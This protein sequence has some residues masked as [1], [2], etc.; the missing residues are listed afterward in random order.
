MTIDFKR[1]KKVKYENIEHKHL[2]FL[3]L[4]LSAKDMFLQLDSLFEGSKNSNEQLVEFFHSIPI[5]LKEELGYKNNM[6]SFKKIDNILKFTLVEKT[7]YTAK[8]TL[9]ADLPNENTLGFLKVA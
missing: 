2:E 4:M 8:N 5:K 1:L 9:F 6:N 3:L 7:L